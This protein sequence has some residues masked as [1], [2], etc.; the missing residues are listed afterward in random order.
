MGKLGK[1]PDV[2]A[3]PVTAGHIYRLDVEGVKAAPTWWLPSDRIELL[4]H[5]LRPCGDCIAAATYAGV[6]FPVG[7]VLNYVWHCRL[8]EPGFDNLMYDLHLILVQPDDAP[9]RPEHHF[10]ARGARRRRLDAAFVYDPPQPAA[11]AAEAAEWQVQGL[12]QFV[13]AN[14]NAPPVMPDLQQLAVEVHVEPED[15]VF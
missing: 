2:W 12:A 7:G 10:P 11:E 8:G 4:R 6:V 13:N 14:V 3:L 1:Q 9:G 5:K 15:G